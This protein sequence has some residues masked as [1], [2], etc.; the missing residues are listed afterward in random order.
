MAELEAQ[1]L[2]FRAVQQNIPDVMATMAAQA[3]LSCIVTAS[4]A[5]L[6]SKL[7]SALFFRPSCPPLAIA[8]D[9]TLSP[10]LQD[11]DPILQEGSP[12]S[13]QYSRYTSN[14]IINLNTV[15]DW[16]MRR[17]V[18]HYVDII[19]PQYPSIS[20]QLLEQTLER[21]EGGEYKDTNAALTY[22]CSPDSGLD[23]FRYFILFIVMAISLMTMNYKDEIQGRATSEL[24]YRSALKH[25]QAMESR[26]EIQE[27]QICL[28]LTFY[29]QCCPE[30]ADNWT[31]IS[32]AVS[33]ILNLGLH[34]QGPEALGADEAHT[35]RQLFWTTY[36]L[37]RSL[38]A[39]LHLPLSFP[40]D[41]ITTSVSWPIVLNLSPIR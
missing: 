35:R 27:L 18:G 17:L 8:R 20:L 1:V 10:R 9:R 11:D 29:A 25:F 40:E 34:K 24:F 15:P 14:S 23:H 22:G 33:I 28:L 32:A 16:L 36:S 26:D 19:L 2:S 21:L 5:S 4:R 30:R 6:Y 31:C 41:S 37:E 7:S 12:S 39:H 13:H 38:C 3:T